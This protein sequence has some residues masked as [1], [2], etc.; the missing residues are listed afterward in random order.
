M[1]TSA[2]N[3]DPW[4]SNGASGSLVEVTNDTAELVRLSVSLARSVWRSGFR[5]AK[6]GVILTE[7]VPEVS[8]QP[9]LWSDVDRERRAELWKVVDGLNLKLGRGTISTLG[10]GGTESSWKLR[11]AFRSPR[12]T[13]QWAELPR[14]KASERENLE[15]AYV[16]RREP[17]GT[18]NDSHI[19]PCFWT[20]SSPLYARSGTTVRGKPMHSNNLHPH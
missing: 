11:A 4:Y 16:S 17:F 1:Y 8:L 3:N 2:H 15:S 12:W 20:S 5:Y 18:F 7:L 19:L 9:A 14:A 6:A 13:T 10:M